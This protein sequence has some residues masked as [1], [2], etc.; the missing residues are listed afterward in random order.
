MKPSRMMFVFVLLLFTFAATNLVW[1][2]PAEKVRV[3]GNVEMWIYKDNQGEVTRVTDQN[4]N[5]AVR[6]NVTDLDITF[7]RHTYKVIRIERSRDGVQIETEGS[8]GCVWRFYGGSW[9]R[10]CS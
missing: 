6:G 2:E 7:G 9:H 3:D 10:I 4:G 5:P 8:P 1:A